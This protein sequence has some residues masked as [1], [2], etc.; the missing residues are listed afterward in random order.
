MYVSLA[1]K[2][3]EEMLSVELSGDNAE[4]YLVTFCLKH[5]PFCDNKASPVLTFLLQWLLLRMI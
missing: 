2:I 4:G 3:D 1:S 5:G